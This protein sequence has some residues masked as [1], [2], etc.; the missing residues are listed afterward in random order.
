MQ[1]KLLPTSK[2]ICFDLDVAFKEKGKRNGALS[3]IFCNTGAV[4][5]SF[6]CC[7]SLAQPAFKQGFSGI[8]RIMRGNNAAQFGCAA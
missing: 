5:Q 6:S 1:P 7:A 3:V 4:F 2:V 8:S